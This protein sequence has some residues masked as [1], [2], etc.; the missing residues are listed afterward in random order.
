MECVATI[1]RRAFAAALT[2]ADPARAVE[3]HCGK[4]RSVY[5][6][7][8]YSRIL[9]IGFGKAAVSMARAAGERLG[10]IIT[11]GAVTTKYGHAAGRVPGKIHV[12][13][14]GHPIPDENGLRGTET[15]LQLA[16]AANEKTLAVVLI[17]GGGSALFVAPCPGVSLE[18]KRETTLLLLK[19]GAEIHELNTVRKH[20]SRVKGGR[21]AEVLSPATIISLIL[22]DVVGDCLDVIASGPTSPDPTT[23]ADALCILE[24]YGLIERAPAAVVESLAKGA[25]GLI[26]ETP[27]AGDPMFRHVENIIIGSNRLALRAA[28]SFAEDA[29]FRSEIL[30]ADISGEAAEAGRKLALKALAAKRNKG[31]DH[32]VCL[33]SGG[34]TTVTVTGAGKGGRNMELALAFALEI[35]G[36]P[37]ITLL[38]AGTDGTDGPTDAAGAI[39][40]GM[41]M[42]RAKSR[43]LDPHGY[44]RDNDSYNF[45][46]KSGGLLITGPT[47]TNVMDIQ[48]VV[49]E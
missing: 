41:T 27:K 47:G 7:G 38:S 10:D 17:S 8:G 16:G 45:F 13:E 4:I 40:D 2:A 19:A 1:V 5:R 14:A 18:E 11:D 44:L 26:A 48:I 31:S 30:S 22:S 6:D 39:V 29:G 37:G 36:I 23:F 34:E 20:L 28:K 35:E 3:R 21:L 46:R 25:K 12:H 32:P 24:K 9:V 33:V 42:T 15:I 49:I 43:G